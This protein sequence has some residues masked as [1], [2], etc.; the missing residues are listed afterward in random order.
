VNAL[1]YSRCWVVLL[2]QALVAQGPL[3]A[4]DEA[5]ARFLTTSEVALKKRIAVTV[6][7]I[8]LQLEPNMAGRRQRLAKGLE[9]TVHAG[10]S[11]LAADLAASLTVDDLQQDDITHWQ[12]VAFVRAERLADFGIAMAK[13]RSRR[14]VS[15]VG[16]VL[17]AEWL[18]LV[19]LADR[20]LRRGETQL[21]RSVFKALAGLE[22]AHPIRL[23]NFALCLR[24]LGEV[25][26]AEQ[27]YEQ[28][29]SLTP[30][31]AQI[32]NDRGLL[33]R[34]SGRPKAARAAFHHSYALDTVS[35]G[36]LGSGP[37]ITN[38]L[39]FEAV[40]PAAKTGAPG[41]PDPLSVAGRALAV[42]SAA[43]MLRRL[44]IDVTLDRLGRGTVPP[45]KI[46]DR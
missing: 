23:A 45:P 3:E 8:F 11:E 2:S 22:P 20:A 31:D 44:V 36:K 12:L 33:L 13:A 10:R 35:G 34:A 7:G 14:Q 46:R 43:T 18:R 40:L 26:A 5:Y 30:N 16:A 42:R 25:E 4:F 39:H 41:T 9:V 38:L 21:G 27:A 32:E 29:M 15:A 24:N 19:P 37:A 1:L 17:L 6:S 28:A